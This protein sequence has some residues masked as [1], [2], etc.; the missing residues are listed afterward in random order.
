[1]AMRIPFIAGNWK[2]FKTKAE[3]KAFAEEFVK[4]YKDTDVK[5]AI[6]AP[7]TDLDTLKEA[8]AGTSIGVGAQNVHFED[9]GA[10][11]GEVSLG[12]HLGFARRVICH[13]CCL[14]ARI[15]AA[16]RRMGRAASRKH[17]HHCRCYCKY[18][19]VFHVHSCMPFFNS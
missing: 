5:T 10:F 11:T 19:S 6:C 15:R 17:D 14:C 3:A 16:G 7:F 2:M 13:G 8:F 18:F 12:K 4:L 9:S 1:M